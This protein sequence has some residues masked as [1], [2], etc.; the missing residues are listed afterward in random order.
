MI[1]SISFSDSSVVMA[2]SK[3]NIKNAAHPTAAVAPTD[4]KD[5]VL[6][7][8]LDS[9]VDDLD[10]QCCTTCFIITSTLCLKN[11]LTFKLSVTLS[12]LNR[13]SKFLHRWKACEMRYK[14]YDITHL[15][16]GT[17]LHY[18]VKLNTQILCQYSADV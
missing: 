4:D 18:L 1:D 5:D 10:G 14:I 16:L 3:N 11:V 12:D 8:K 15:T 17:L 9:F 13:F 6:D 2:T 7:A